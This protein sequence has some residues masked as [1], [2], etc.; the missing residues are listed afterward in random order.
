[1]NAVKKFV[2]KCAEIGR[3]Y[4]PWGWNDRIGWAASELAG[5][6]T[7]KGVRIQNDDSALFQR[8]CQ[9][10]ARAMRRAA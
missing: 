2:R 4:H 7:Y 8:G 5:S 6:H 9:I 1:M 3:N 10:A